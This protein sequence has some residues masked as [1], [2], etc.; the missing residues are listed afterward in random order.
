MKAFVHIL[1]TIL[2]IVFIISAIF[3]F[4]SIDE[5]EIYVF[6]H[7]LMSFNLSSLA[8]RLLIGFEFF[9]GIMLIANLYFRQI[10]MTSVAMLSGFTIYLAITAIS[11]SSENCHCFGELLKMNPIE[12]MIKNGILLIGFIAIRKNMSFSLK[13]KLLLTTSVALIS[14][15]LPTIVSPPDFFYPELYSKIAVINKN[16][17]DSLVIDNNQFPVKCDTGK[18]VL[19]FYSTKCRFCKLSERKICSIVERHNLDSTKFA[20]IFWGDST[21]SLDKFYQSKSIRFESAFINTNDFM[22]ITGGKM[23]LI[24]LI[25]DKKIIERF[26]YRSIDEAKIVQFLK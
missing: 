11:G 9:I 20:N 5:F 1:R 18:K 15:S 13:Y 3:K 26:G 14:L 17:L 4:L 10:W 21:T 8:A 16:G 19:C 23:P 7:N 25:E 2:G 6:S 12:S 24:L 22:S